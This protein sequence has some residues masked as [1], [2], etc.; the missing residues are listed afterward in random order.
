MSLLFLMIKNA[1]IPRTIPNTMEAKAH[2]NII[3]SLDKLDVFAASIFLS[4]TVSLK[5]K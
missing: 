1:A 4:P 3:D 5:T 2:A